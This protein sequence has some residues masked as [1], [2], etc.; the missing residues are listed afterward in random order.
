VLQGGGE[1][2]KSAILDSGVVKALGDYASAA[3]AK[4]FLSTKG[5][6][7]STEM[8]DL[9]G[10]RL[11]LAEE[12]AENRS[13]DVTSLK[14]IQDVETIKARYIRKDNIQFDTTHSLFT[15]SNYEPVVNETDHG[16]WRRLALLVFPYRFRKPDEPQEKA[17]DRPGDP[18]LKSRIK[19]SSEVADA[20]VTWVVEGAVS[21]ADNPDAFHGYLTPKIKDDTRRWRKKADRILG[22]WDEL[23]V[24]DREKGI[25][26]TDL[27][28]AFNDWLKS[29]G[30]HTWPQETFSQRF[31]GHQE[32]ARHGV[33]LR[34]TKKLDGVVDLYVSPSDYDELDRPKKRALPGKAR[35]WLGVR[36][37]T[38]SDTPEE[39][40]EEARSQGSQ[41]SGISLAK[42]SLKTEPRGVGTFGTSDGSASNGDASDDPDWAEAEFARK[43]P[44][45]PDGEL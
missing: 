18:T 21:V 11:M 34:Q 45:Q 36:F 9:R 7:H 33:E 24:A 27:F 43:Y 41:P 25:V 31:G 40:P 1:N 26:S 30:H 20:V 10:Q 19:T 17:T 3:S 44:D 22:F 32:T 2:G 6:E 8:A 39:S 15:T 38:D 23:L 42:N 12:I 28:Q 35:V 5:N 37:A 4:L 16:T 14:R 29:N 13:I